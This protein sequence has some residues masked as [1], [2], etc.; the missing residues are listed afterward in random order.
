MYQIPGGP[1]ADLGSFVSRPQ[2]G[3]PFGYGQTQMQ[4]E[5]RPHA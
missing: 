3:T 1:N 2:G 5:S 4:N